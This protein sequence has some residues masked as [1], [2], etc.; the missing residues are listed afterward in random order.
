MHAQTTATSTALHAH[1]AGDPRSVDG[2]HRASESRH[3]LP[4]WAWLVGR[5]LGAV[6]VLVAGVIHLQQYYGPYSA[7]PTIGTLFVVN[8]VAATVVG[9]ALLAPLE[10]MAGRWAGPVVA[11]ASA[12]G[13]A[14]TAGSF[15]MLLISERTPLFGFRESGYDASTIALTRQSEIA[16]VILLS[17][18]L[19]LRFA[20]RTPKARW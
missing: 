16:A 8:F 17:A 5:S 19:I 20:T 18:S 6:A 2:A 9:L 11:I 15:A 12:G 3:W 13:L 7:I 4:P 14:L 10:H 1:D